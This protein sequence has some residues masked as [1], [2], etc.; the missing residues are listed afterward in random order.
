MERERFAECREEGV[1]E[2]STKRATVSSVERTTRLIVETRQ[3]A[4]IRQKWGE[5]IEG[6]TSG[7]TRVIVER[8]GRPIAALI[9]TDELACLEEV[10]RGLAEPVRRL[11]YLQNVLGDVLPEELSR[12]A[13]SIERMQQEIERLR[14]VADI[15]AVD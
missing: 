15:Q 9:S 5:V 12:M 8:Y 14:K 11:T 10:E 2:S 13:Q 4:E 7:R 3:A 1:N 6:V